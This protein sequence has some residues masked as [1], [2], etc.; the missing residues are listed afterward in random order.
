MSPLHIYRAGGTGEACTKRCKATG[1]RF[2]SGKVASRGP[3]AVHDACHGFVNRHF[4][5]LRAIALRH[6]SLNYAEV[7][8]SLGS[9]RS[10]YGPQRSRPGPSSG[11]RAA[12]SAHTRLPFFIGHALPI[13]PDRLPFLAAVAPARSLPSRLPSACF[14]ICLPFS[15]FWRQP[16]RVTD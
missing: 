15:G 8:T 13:A 7:M 11:L 3:F 5:L 6:A 14:A 16:N 1:S 12:S 9:W 10:S 2:E 4:A